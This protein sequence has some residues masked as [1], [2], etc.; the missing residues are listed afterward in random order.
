LPSEITWRRDKTGFEPPQKLWMQS[1]TVQ[2][3]IKEAKSKLVKEKILKPEVLNKKIEPLGSND[4]DN[5]D[6]RYLSASILF[7]PIP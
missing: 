6:W 2:Q 1:D 4:A 3:M 7:A 5:F